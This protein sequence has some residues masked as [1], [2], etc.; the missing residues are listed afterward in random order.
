MPYTACAV[1][2]SDDGQICSFIKI[3]DK[4][5]TKEVN[6]KKNKKKLINSSLVPMNNILI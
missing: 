4:D 2:P 6:V 3:K 5:Y 1:D